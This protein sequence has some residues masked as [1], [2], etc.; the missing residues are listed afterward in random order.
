M[1]WLR[2]RG[3]R[4]SRAVSLAIAAA[5]SFPMGV[6]A[7]A[8][9]GEL[10]ALR[11]L[12]SAPNGTR[13]ALAL[14]YVERA[15]LQLGDAIPALRHQ[16]T[17]SALNSDRPVVL[18]VRL[19]RQPETAAALRNYR[20]QGGRRRLILWFPT[21]AYPDLT[22]E[23]QARARLDQ[24][25]ADLGASLGGMGTDN[26]RRLLDP[27][28][29]EVVLAAT[30]A[31]ALELY[32]EPTASRTIFDTLGIPPPDTLNETDRFLVDGLV[33]RALDSLPADQR[34]AQQTTLYEALALR[35]LS[36]L[37]P[38]A[39]TARLI[40]AGLEPGL[41]D[42]LVRE[43]SAP[44][45]MADSEAWR[46]TVERHL[47]ILEAAALD[48]DLAANESAAAY[49]PEEE[50]DA[51]E[52]EADLAENPYMR[53]AHHLRDKVYE[54]VALAGAQ[55][56]QLPPPGASDA[57]WR[58]FLLAFVT[59][60]TARSFV[61]R[62]LERA[63]AG[64]ASSGKSWGTQADLPPLSV[65]RKHQLHS[66]VLRPEADVTLRRAGLGGWLDW[67]QGQD[68]DEGDELKV[69]VQRAL[70]YAN[71][72]LQWRRGMQQFVASLLARPENARIEFIFVEPIIL[73][74]NHMAR[75]YDE[76]RGH[77]VIAIDLGF[78]ENS[79]R[80]VGHR[81]GG[82]IVG[83][84]IVAERLL[85]EL[86][87]DN[88]IRSYEEE[89]AEELRILREADWM[90]FEAFDG[91]A[92]DSD[93]EQLLQ[94]L[95]EGGRHAVTGK[96]KYQFFQELWA[97][98]NA[99][100]GVGERERLIDEGLLAFARTVI[101]RDFRRFGK[102]AGF[103]PEAGI[104]L[105]DL[106][107]WSNDGLI[108]LAFDP[109][110]EQ[111]A[112]AQVNGDAVTVRLK[113]R[114]SRMLGYRL[115][116]D[117]DDMTAGE[118][119][120][121]RWQPDTLVL[122]RRE[123][124]LQ[125]AARDTPL[126]DGEVIY[127]LPGV[128]GPKAGSTVSSMRRPAGWDETF[129]TV[130]DRLAVSEGVKV[131]Y[132]ETPSLAAGP[133]AIWLD[134]LL[135]ED[136]GPLHL[137]IQVTPAATAGDIKR[138]FANASQYEV[139]GQ[140]FNAIQQDA[141]GFRLF[142]DLGGG[143]PALPP[144]GRAPETVR[145]VL[146]E[147]VTPVRSQEI[148]LRSAFV[149]ATLR[150]LSEEDT[151]FLSALLGISS[152]DPRLGVPSEF[153]VFGTQGD[154]P[155][156]LARVTMVESTPEEQQG[157][158]TVKTTF[159][160]VV[161]GTLPHG[162][163]RMA[164]YV[165]IASL[166]EWERLGG[167]IL[168]AIPLH[169]R[170]PVRFVLATS[171]RPFTMNFERGTG[172]TVEAIITEESE[173]A[174]PPLP[175]GSVTALMNVEDDTREFSFKG[176]PIQLYVAP[177]RWR[178]ESSASQL[179]R[180][181]NLKDDVPAA[182]Y[183]VF[184]T[185][186]HGPI[187]LA[188]VSLDVTSVEY[189]ALEDPSSPQ[190]HWMLETLPKYWGQSVALS[191]LEDR[192]IAGAYFD[193]VEPVAGERVGD[194]H[195][196]VLPARFSNGDYVNPNEWEPDPTHSERIRLIGYPTVVARR[197]D[198][199]TY[200]LEGGGL[201]FARR[202]GG[203]RVSDADREWT[204]KL[205]VQ[206][207]ADLEHAE[208]AGPGQ[209][210]ANELSAWKSQVARLLVPRSEVNQ[211][212]GAADVP[213]LAAGRTGDWEWRITR[214]T[215][216][217]AALDDYLP[218]GMKGVRF[219]QEGRP[220]I[221]ESYVL[222][223]ERAGGAIET[224]APD[225]NLAETRLHPGDSLFLTRTISGGSGD[226]PAQPPGNVSYIPY[227]KSDYYTA[228][229][230]VAATAHRSAAYITATLVRAFVEELERQ[231][232]PLESVLDYV[233]DVS[234]ALDR[235]SDAFN[236]EHSGGRPAPIERQ[237]IQL[238]SAREAVTG[239]VL[240]PLTVKA[241]LDDPR[242]PTHAAAY[243]LSGLSDWAARIGYLRA[244]LSWLDTTGIP[245]AERASEP[246]Q[247]ERLT[248]LR[249]FAD[250][251]H[252]VLEAWG[253][254]VVELEFNLRSLKPGEADERPK[255]WWHPVQVDEPARRHG[256]DPADVRAALLATGE[257]VERSPFAG[258]IYG[259]TNAERSLLTA[260]P[261]SLYFNISLAAGDYE[262]RVETFTTALHART[263][264]LP[265]QP[266]SG[267]GPPIEDEEG[268]AVEP[269]PDDPSTVV[270]PD[271]L[272]GRGFAYDIR[273]QASDA[274]EERGQ[275][276]Q[277]T[278]TPD[279]AR[280]IA[281]ALGS[282]HR[283][284]A[285]ALIT[286]DHRESGP[287]LR[288]AVIEGLRSVGMNVETTDE[289]MPTGATSR[290][291]LADGYDLTIQISGSHNPWYANGLKITEKQN[292]AGEPA[293]EGIPSAVFG[294]ALLDVQQVIETHSWRRNAPEGTLTVLDRLVDEY[295]DALDAALP[296]LKPG[297]RV[298]V[299][300][301]NG[302]GARPMVELL[303]RRGVEVVEL[304]SEPHPRFPNH[305]ADPSRDSVEAPYAESGVRHL[306]EKVRE[307][308]AALA[309]GEVPW[310]GIS[311][312]GDGDRSAFV[313]EQGQ[314]IAP[315]RLLVA[316]YHRFILENL[317]A[318]AK[319]RTVG[320]TTKLALDVRASGIVEQLFDRYAGVGGLFIP[321]GYPSHRKFV[322]QQIA[323]IRKIA[324]G[325][326][327]ADDPDI[328]RLINTYTS[329]EASGHYFYATDPTH[330]DIKIDDGIFTAVLGL[331]ILDT[332]AE[333]EA[334][335]L[336]VSLPR[337]DRYGTK[338]FVAIPNLPVTTDIR[339][340]VAD[341]AKFRIMDEAKAL[342]LA[343]YGSQVKPTAGAWDIDGLKVQGPDDGVIEVDGVRIALQDG[344]W[345]LIRASNTSPMLTYKVEALTQERVVELAAEVYEIL[346]TF[347][348]QGLS[349]EGFAK[350]LERQRQIGLR[351][352]AQPPSGSSTAEDGAPAQPVT[353]AER[354]AL[355][356]LKPPAREIMH[357]VR[358]GNLSFDTALNRLLQLLGLKGTWAVAV[359]A[360]LGPGPRTVQPDSTDDVLRTAIDELRWV[361]LAPEVQQAVLG[362]L[363]DTRADPGKDAR[364]ARTIDRLLRLLDLTQAEVADPLGPRGSWDGMLPASRGGPPSADDDDLRRI[365]GSPEAVL[366]GLLETAQQIRETENHEQQVEL[367]VGF[368]DQLPRLNGEFQD[369]LRAQAESDVASGL[370][371]AAY[372][373]ALD[374]L[375]H[376]FI[377]DEPRDREL[378]Y[379]LA[380]NGMLRR[381][382][383][384]NLR[385]PLPAAFQPNPPAPNAPIPTANEFQRLQRLDQA[386]I[387][388]RATAGEERA[389]R[390]RPPP[391]A[392]T[393]RPTW[394]RIRLTR[395]TSWG[396]PRTSARSTR[397]STRPGKKGR[398][399]CDA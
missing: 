237:A 106:Q 7:V 170:E 130:L 36:R 118:L 169:F 271:V 160:G 89:L 175:P 376:A 214:E 375:S 204:E 218:A 52:E 268:E 223:I 177:L 2:W 23:T 303:R 211:P 176:Q 103:S 265:A 135:L 129:R 86:S 102:A 45:A 167:A 134:S 287:A 124:R 267:G 153:M 342:A 250:E 16:F 360:N 131:T 109:A 352:A 133:V 75:Y 203:A 381:H 127:V 288:Q 105:R 35:H 301:G 76:K 142:G 28:W 190:F 150:G 348:N 331:S 119:L 296:Q 395:C 126:D 61:H 95:D 171:P 108:R 359:L 172:S 91:A 90:L 81:G 66:V 390:S 38:G 323:E 282:R 158:A 340:P 343:R 33:Q 15:F 382:V 221:E 46:R 235:R 19:L 22:T 345:F 82:R 162:F 380:P 85:H 207:F 357:E 65:V 185:S 92:E 216:V 232:A 37:S 228:P 384:I 166:D 397:R 292:S 320:H 4:A 337:Q 328:Q 20:A 285:R 114:T 11:P 377:P 325:H 307:L 270:L 141:D 77:P 117:D 302:V 74:G 341:E 219:P 217:E 333:Y 222:G 27:A 67:L 327:L 385:E 44:T 50:Y 369:Q 248:S 227:A 278:L 10:D 39:T 371:P 93:V 144:G 161:E 324:A 358:R 317:P 280:L 312:D 389:S 273:G 224:L 30:P 275:Y 32:V 321:A 189:L 209:P 98:A 311:L 147:A 322:R 305:P 210:T 143:L 353:I 17:P 69:W 283:A 164:E 110:M 25:L 213:S 107:Q 186:T 247:L 300:A 290:K 387:A 156:I 330:P 392:A 159:P 354:D 180:L 362:A 13:Q 71:R 246:A 1:T 128:A 192:L 116:A 262:A 255:Q 199:G 286:M 184:G 34:E 372:H 104:T 215:T 43:A 229:D 398:H 31:E 284:G 257:F 79:E 245:A 308:N 139:R 168:D 277:V 137:S 42:A 49:G 365:L 148:D 351:Q 201:P 26:A 163:V 29:F 256:F 12:A 121:A 51:A 8:A 72:R 254:F 58:T 18:D 394:P 149:A 220:K 264:G 253:D 239:E 293:P 309:P 298:V 125:P 59:D 40:G 136:G 388:V 297:H 151:Q 335:S 269:I 366:S 56:E 230:E 200:D 123:G 226:Q 259:L 96:V 173:P 243:C 299:D 347:M 179:D 251:Q 205:E 112:E 154:G 294:R 78:F 68:E 24:V 182:R 295:I 258:Q 240:V 391:A 386:L 191:P 231:Q 355:E 318:I 193:Y 47:S 367:A 319:L 120:G 3:S 236:R 242:G 368:L 361:A 316:L 260:P 338:V 393:G 336:A 334:Q 165:P 188:R 62:E 261:G 356:R 5:V 364:Q 54:L 6:P 329:A 113:D 244:L 196:T 310:I 373:A 379:Q 266:P 21:A 326:G 145:A 100:T 383:L 14:Q 146:E 63:A 241:A 41:V 363:A 152:E 346:K 399:G 87:H 206:R 339:D 272:F 157:L 187:L 279:G 178:E 97:K 314:P 138:A 194:V 313:D 88:E 53:T 332:A 73:G 115:V 263:L 80:V 396:R 57:E 155:I 281:R 101:S 122:V 304:F 225:A 291:A 9:M 252:A 181:L 370:A 276:N 48:A 212:D 183:V 132:Q 64:H 238:A 197:N 249:T 84:R 234:A 208:A 83:S 344:S 195:V 94:L 233:L 374:V 140:I 70:R 111:P 378:L 99:A 350:E 55:S 60:N 349:V 289:F 174:Q 306:S 202:R 315:E 274:P 198:D